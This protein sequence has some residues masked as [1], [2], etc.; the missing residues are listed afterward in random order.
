MVWAFFAG[1][2]GMCTQLMDYGPEPLGV[3]LI[4]AGLGLVYGLLNPR[5]WRLSFL[6]AWAAALAWTVFTLYF[7]VLSPW[8]EADL[9]GEMAQQL[10]RLPT[11]VLSPLLGALVGGF[12]GMQART[13]LGPRLGR[14]E[15]GHGSK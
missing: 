13:R 8:T 12:C 2:F 1:F 5:Y 11:M 7:T 6:C 15:V 10:G 4:Y 9:V 14:P 3:F